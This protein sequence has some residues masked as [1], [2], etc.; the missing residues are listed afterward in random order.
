MSL[1]VALRSSQGLSLMKVITATEK[2]VTAP[3]HPSTLSRD[4]TLVAT[5][6]PRFD[7]DWGRY[8]II[9]GNPMEPI[10]KAFTAATL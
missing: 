9:T 3:F 10:P 8:V 2:R 7:Y 4:S 6:H 1:S 5:T